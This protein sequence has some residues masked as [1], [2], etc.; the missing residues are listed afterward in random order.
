MID[1]EGTPVLKIDQR[2]GGEVYNTLIY[3]RD[4]Q[5]KELFSREDSGLTLDDGMSIMQ[6]QG[7]QFEMPKQDLLKVETKGE[8][9]GSI[10]LT[11]RSG[12]AGH[13]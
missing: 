10:I 2:Y 5:I 9:S 12:E 1:M 6:S 4:G 8:N 11:L 7:I 13:E 3:F